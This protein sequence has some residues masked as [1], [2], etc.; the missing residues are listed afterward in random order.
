MS[1]Q[2]DK[3]KTKCKSLGSVKVAKRNQWDVDSHQNS[4]SDSIEIDGLFDFLTQMIGYRPFGLIHSMN[5][6]DA[7]Q[8]QRRHEPS[9]HPSSSSSSSRLLGRTATNP[10]TID[11]DPITIDAVNDESVR[12]LSRPQ[13]TI[14]LTIDEDA[15]SNRNGPMPSSSRSDQYRPTEAPKVEA[16]LSYRDLMTMYGEFPS[17]GDASD[18]DYCEDHLHPDEMDDQIQAEDEDEDGDDFDDDDV[19]REYD[20]LGRRNV[21][22]RLSGDVVFCDRCDDYHDIMRLYDDS[23]YCTFMRGYLESR[24]QFDY[25]ESRGRRPDTGHPPVSIDLTVSSSSGSPL[26]EETAGNSSSSTTEVTSTTVVGRRLRRDIGISGRHRSKRLFTSSEELTNPSSTNNQINQA[27]SDSSNEN[28]RR[29]ARSS[30]SSSSSSS[31]VRASD[32]SERQ[33]VKRSRQH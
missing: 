25:L 33:H 27:A 7:F 17:D 19:V 11:A 18:E 13:N 3:S 20:S 2:D 32:V 16:D 8:Q 6:L 22:Y 30:S 9:R 23:T 5:R 14:D 1:F 31:I 15:V 24:G 29:I 26:C 28:S 10:I 21:P 12:A 4:L